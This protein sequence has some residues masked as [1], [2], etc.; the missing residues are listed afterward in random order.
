MTA[1]PTTDKI[2]E[3]LAKHYKFL[4]E[5]LDENNV[6]MLRERLARISETIPKATWLR[7]AAQY[8]LA[9]ARQ[10]ARTELEEKCLTATVLRNAVEDATSEHLRAFDLT[11]KLHQDLTNLSHNIR[12]LLDFEIADYRNNGG[13]EGRQRFSK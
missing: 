7:S 9:E 11:R 1:I 13:T 6:T 12:K 4:N 8:R 10:S 5:P 3:E 2:I